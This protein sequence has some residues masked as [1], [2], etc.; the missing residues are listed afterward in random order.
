MAYEIPDYGRP[1]RSLGLR[2]YI[3]RTGSR[4]AT[5]LVAKELRDVRGSSLCQSDRI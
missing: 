1:K 5:R 3:V 4:D 2:C